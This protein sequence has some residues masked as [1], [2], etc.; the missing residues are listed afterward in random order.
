MGGGELRRS[1]NR[2]NE[3]QRLLR[4]HEPAKG[5]GVRPESEFLRIEFGGLLETHDALVAA[6]LKKLLNVHCPRRP[7]A[8]DSLGGGAFRLRV[9]WPSTFA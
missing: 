1:W 7:T 3:Y 5:V 4:T 9:P 8:C 2:A 6:D